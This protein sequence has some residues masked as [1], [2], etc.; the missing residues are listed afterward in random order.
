MLRS[1]ES[2]ADEVYPLLD[3]EDQS[4]LS[5]DRQSVAHRYNR[6]VFDCS[7]CLVQCWLLDR[8]QQLCSMTPTGVLVSPLQEQIQEARDFEDTT[9]SYKPELERLASLAEDCRSSASAETAVSESVLSSEEARVSARVIELTRR[10]DALAVALGDRLDL[11]NGHV[12]TLQQFASSE[13]A[14]STLLAEWERRVASLPPPGATSATLQTQ[15]HDT[16]VC[17]ANPFLL[18]MVIV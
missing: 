6:V 10:Y 12:P 8:E 18:I 7:C 11:L 13:R 1:L 3:D 16:M 9:K 4:T 15:L 14:W 17:T 5:K 2:A